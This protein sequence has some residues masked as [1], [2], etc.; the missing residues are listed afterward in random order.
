MGLECGGLGADGEEFDFQE[1]LVE[2]RHRH[3]EAEL[4]R[5][6]SSVSLETYRKEG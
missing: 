1:L 6:S 4:G 5:V 2:V 3:V